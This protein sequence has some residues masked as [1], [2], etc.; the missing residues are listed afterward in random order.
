MLFISYGYCFGMHYTMPGVDQHPFWPDEEYE[1]VAK[2]CFGHVQKLQALEEIKKFCEKKQV[3][4]QEILNPYIKLHLHNDVFIGK[5]DKLAEEEKFF[6][7]KW[8]DPELFINS[9]ITDKGHDNTALLRLFF[10][11]FTFQVQDLYF[12]AR[13]K[14][15]QKV[16]PN[17]CYKDEDDPRIVELY[18]TKSDR[19]N[20]LLKE[21]I[22]VT[23]ALLKCSDES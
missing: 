11:D 10:K 16:D 13:N 14:I 12:K 20:A 7:V 21:A 15:I 5:E 4:W 23:Q 3:T 1:A 22:M 19:L 8:D 9:K 17:Y 2:D 6:F 18:R